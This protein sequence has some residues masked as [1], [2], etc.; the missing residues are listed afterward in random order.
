[1]KSIKFILYVYSAKYTPDSYSEVEI[2]EQS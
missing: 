1:M 2:N